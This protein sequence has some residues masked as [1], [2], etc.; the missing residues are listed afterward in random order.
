[1]FMGLKNRTW[2][3]LVASGTISSIPNLAHCVFH[4]MLQALDF[5]AANEI[6]HRD[7]KPEN[8]RFTSLSHAQYSFQ[9]G[10]FGLCNRAVS[11]ATSVGSPLYM[12]LEMLQEGDQTH[13]ADVWS[14]YVTMVWTMNV[15]EFRQ[16]SE[17]FKSIGDAR[18]AI[19]ARRCR[20]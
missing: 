9:L 8:I 18:E 16:R 5:L 11:A 3:S 13:K 1:M 6:I 7:V 14:L 15:E 19:L 17:Q 4:R 20:C 12:A 2:R 10:D